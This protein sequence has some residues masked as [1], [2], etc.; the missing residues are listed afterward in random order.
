[1]SRARQSKARGFTLI[2]V[3]MVLGLAFVGLFG[4]TSVLIV[5]QRSAQS[6][7]FITEGTQL[8][9]DKLEQMEHMQLATLV[10]GVENGL[11]PQGVAVAGGAYTRTTT[12]ALNGAV[13][14]IRVQ[15]GWSDSNGRAHSALFITQRAP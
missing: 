7:R 4:L 13:T 2:E 12:V 6:A 14:T 1:M 3:M 8:A 10:S 9:Q 15:V 5:A 11:G